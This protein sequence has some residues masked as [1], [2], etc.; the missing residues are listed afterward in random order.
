MTYGMELTHLDLELEYEQLVSL[1]VTKS[2]APFTLECSPSRAIPEAANLNIPESNDKTPWALP[3]VFIDYTVPEPNELFVC[4]HL[5]C[6][7]SYTT[8]SSLKR[9]IIATHK[10]KKY[11]CSCG[12]QFAFNYRYKQH[13][14]THTESS[15]IKVP[16]KQVPKKECALCQKG[17]K[18]KKQRDTHIDRKHNFTKTFE[19]SFA[20]CKESYTSRSSLNLH[21][22][23]KHREAK[24]VCADLDCDKKYSMECDLNQHCA[25]TGHKKPHSD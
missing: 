13:Y 4:P 20:E 7:K 5:D 24:F 18:S 16:K 8:N 12:K 15:K 14:Q 22:L 21:F 9:H 1:D 6:D 23:R 17:F 10:E 2:K 3:Y 25:R 11:I 19:C